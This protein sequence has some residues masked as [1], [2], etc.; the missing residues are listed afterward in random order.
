MNTYPNDA[1]YQ[2]GEQWYIDAVN[3]P[4]AWDSVT[5]D[6]SQIIGIIDTGVDWDHPDLDGNIWKNWGEIPDNGLDDDGNGFIDDVRGWD[7]TS[8]SNDPDDDN[9]HGT[10]VAGVVAAETNNYVGISGIAWNA[11]IM[12]IKV[13]TGTG[14][15][16]T[17]WLA[18]AIYYAANN[19]ATYQLI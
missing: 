13:L 19:G 17:A 12:P 16:N 4:A 15:G 1:L 18:S 11:R 14:S 5:C 6:T 10:H 9:G 8:N 7:F 3:A 2:S